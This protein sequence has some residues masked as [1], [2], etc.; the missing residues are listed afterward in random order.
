MR[1]LLLAGL[2]AAAPAFADSEA[3]RG[4]DW[5]RLT[6]KPCADEKVLQHMPDKQAHLGYRA[7]IAR[8]EGKEYNAC[9]KP[10][11]FMGAEG[12][13]LVYEDGDAGFVPRAELKPVKEV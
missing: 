2:L 12:A 13:L 7:A 5:V 9:W 8:Y 3:R 6:L 10:G 4:D 11:V 1:L